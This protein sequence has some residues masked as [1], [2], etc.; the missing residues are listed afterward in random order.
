MKAGQ[1]FVIAVLLCGPAFAE[2]GTQSSTA[3]AQGTEPTIAGNGST[4][5][6]E[7]SSSTT[8]QAPP[9][10]RKAR[11]AARYLPTS[12]DYESLPGRT[13]RYPSGNAAGVGR[14]LPGDKLHERERIPPQDTPYPW[15]RRPSA[16]NVPFAGE[17]PL[18]PS[19]SLQEHPL[20]AEED[21]SFPK[22]RPHRPGGPGPFYP[23]NR[24]PS[25]GGASFSGASRDPNA[26]NL[27]HP[28]YLGDTLSVFDDALPHPSDGSH[29]LE[30]T[31]G[32]Q[33]QGEKDSASPERPY[34]LGR[35]PLRRPLHPEDKTFDVED[36][37]FSGEP[38]SLDPPRL[39]HPPYL[40]ESPSN[41]DVFARFPSGE[42]DTPEW[43][44]GDKLP[45][46]QDFAFPERPH[47]PERPAQRKPSYPEDELYDV[48]GTPFPR[49]T[50]FSYNPGA[51]HLRHPPY[52]GDERPTSSNVDDV[53]RSPSLGSH[54]GEWIPGHKLITRPNLTFPERPH[55]PGRPPLL[56][57]L[58][59]GDKLTGFEDVSFPRG[60]PYRPDAPPL[61]EPPQT[62]LRP[63]SVDY[64]PGFPSGGSHTP[65]WTP[66]DK[67]PSGSSATF[68]ERPH[69]PGRPPL[70]HPLRPGDN[71]SGF[72]DAF[73]SRERPHGPETPRPQHASPLGDRPSSVNSIPR[74]PS[75]SHNPA[76]TLRDKLPSEQY[77]AV[78]DGRPH[79]PGRPPLQHPLHPGDKLHGVKSLPPARQRPRIPESS[80][81]TRAP[82]RKNKVSSTGHA[83]FQGVKSHGREK[84]PRRRDR[85]T[86]R[87]GNTSPVP[88][89]RSPTRA[90][91]IK[92]V[93]A[94][95]GNYSLTPLA[96]HFTGRS[97]QRQL[98]TSAR[99][100][101]RLHSALKSYVRPKHNATM[102]RY[103]P[104]PAHGIAADRNSPFLRGRYSSKQRLPQR[105]APY[106]MHERDNSQFTGDKPQD[107]FMR[108]R[109]HEPEKLPARH[110]SFPGNTRPK[111]ND[112][113]WKDHI[114]ERPY[115][116][117]EGIPPRSP[118]YQGGSQPNVDAPFSGERSQGVGDSSVQNTWHLDDNLSTEKDT[119]FTG[120][121]PHAVEDPFVQHPSYLE[122][123]LPHGEGTRFPG[124]RPHG[125]E[126][127][128]LQHSSN[129]GDRFP[130][131]KVAPGL[132]AP[133]EGDSTPIEVVSDCPP[134]MCPEHPTP[135]P[136]WPEGLDLP[137]Q[138]PGEWLG[139]SET[140]PHADNG[141][142]YSPF[143]SERHDSP[144]MTSPPYTPPYPEG[145]LH[146]GAISP[147]RPSPLD[148]RY[149]P[150]PEYVLPDRGYSSWP[151][152]I[153]YSSGG[154]PT[155][156]EYP[157]VPV[158]VIRV[159]TGGSP[160]DSGV[161]L[162]VSS[163]T[164]GPQSN[165]ALLII[166]DESPAGPHQRIPTVVPPYSPVSYTQ[167][168]ETGLR[169]P[170]GNPPQ[171]FNFARASRRDHQHFLKKDRE[172]LQMSA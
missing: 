6:V 56:H 145:N 87:A 168:A 26:P 141:H 100:G 14:P 117:S 37:P 42:S 13:P 170:R 25:V 123:Q 47:R 89:E 66:G 49:G 34:R 74:F 110:L 41:V 163:S 93:A 158:Q 148:K 152:E 54:T 33:L 24:K 70:R 76:W 92:R 16:D 153:P 84:L 136:G 50:L 156:E 77:L 64:I 62:G 147:L 160:Y 151:R 15:N 29:A 171:Y 61:L 46:G 130:L 45:S 19:W 124:E 11:S 20:Y 104:Y 113:R 44:I 65:E 94:L 9:L 3:T 69:R 17:G 57:P 133:D 79:R 88:T 106:K 90:P 143:L 102:P 30:W 75:G 48:D 116:S 80:A 122:D 127:P 39:G 159:P 119:P 72:E 162:V 164:D 43:S 96:S 105:Y 157:E 52:L 71:L 126:G 59:P 167:F 83:P 21:S 142:D 53:L 58:R 78:E 165:Y 28:P 95:T 86:T 101:R 114:E 2:R 121:R 38:H 161:M 134:Y 138:L 135:P 129:P 139:G 118:L 8:L 97:G 18:T 22:G 166:P 5:P 31:L 172:G 107:S 82:G 109:L 68:F 111:V 85:R 103:P 120:E 51:P 73:I 91:P 12:S 27:R 112:K 55:R 60:T 98:S 36:V 137:V 10:L 150:S 7:Q 81:L 115:I 40:A 155:S 35:P 169:Y 128:F 154:F 32:D 132:D 108:E 1:A 146:D 67:V 144:E 131:A 149:P 125:V 23:G 63:P 140:L 4:V 99:R